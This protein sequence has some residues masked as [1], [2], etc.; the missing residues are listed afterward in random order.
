MGIYISGFAFIL[1]FALVWHILWLGLLGFIGATACVI[2]R[3]F[4]EHTEYVL[5]G[6]E[7]AKIEMSKARGFI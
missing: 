4:D 2:I 3:S 7:V 5:P 6:T 1:A